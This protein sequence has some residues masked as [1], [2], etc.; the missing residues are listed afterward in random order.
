MTNGLDQTSP[1]HGYF[2]DTS[3]KTNLGPAR[4]CSRVTGCF[5]PDSNLGTASRDGEG[6]MGDEDEDIAGDGDNNGIDSGV[7]HLVV[8]LICIGFSGKSG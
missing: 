3:L 7:L 8:G 5:K 6:E 1:S 2:C 4:S